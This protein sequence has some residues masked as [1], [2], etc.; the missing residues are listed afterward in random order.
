M[1]IT[2]IQ[3]FDLPLTLPEEKQ[4]HKNE[5]GFEKV[6]NDTINNLNGLIKKSRNSF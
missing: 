4:V 1:N 5:N 2:E 6:L 3:G